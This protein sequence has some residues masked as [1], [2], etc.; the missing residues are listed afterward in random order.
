MTM[1]ITRS[2]VMNS[3]TSSRSFKPVA[4]LNLSQ[5]QFPQLDSRKK[6]KRKRNKRRR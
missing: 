1:E 2:L 6:R 3:R 5:H 4:C